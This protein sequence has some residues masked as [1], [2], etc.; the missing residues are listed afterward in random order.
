MQILNQSFETVSDELD[1]YALE[2]LSEEKA[3]RF[4]TRAAYLA[5]KQKLDKFPLHTAAGFD[6]VP[7]AAL[8][9]L[10]SGGCDINER[11]EDGQ[12]PLKNAVDSHHYGKVRVLLRHDNIEV[13]P[14]DSQRWTPLHDACRLGFLDIVRLL[15]DTGH[16]N[17]EARNDEGFTPLQVAP[18]AGTPRSSPFSSTVRP[19]RPRPVTTGLSRSTAP[20][21]TTIPKRSRHS[22]AER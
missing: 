3:E 21:S 12:T 8:E 18:L 6:D 13:D 19:T 14:V 17:I 16:A 7:A 15:C 4:L 2:S 10:I 1:L 22:S 11:D 20:F 9:A 5:L